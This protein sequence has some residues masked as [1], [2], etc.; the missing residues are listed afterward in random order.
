MPV[1]KDQRCK[2][3]GMQLKQ[4]KMKKNVAQNRGF[5]YRSTTAPL[6]AQFR[7]EVWMSLE[8]KLIG[9]TVCVIRNRIGRTALR[10]LTP[11]CFVSAKYEIES[12]FQQ[13]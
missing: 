12:S 13:C 11:F 2:S 1:L 7:E 5:R 8:K 6:Q 3:F 4:Q 9:S 10:Q